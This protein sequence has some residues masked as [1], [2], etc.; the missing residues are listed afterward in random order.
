MISGRVCTLLP[1]GSLWKVLL[2]LRFRSESLVF[3]L[4]PLG[5]NEFLSPPVLLASQTP[6]FL[7]DCGGRLG[8]F[9]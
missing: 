5:L 2:V 4:G 1:P 7:R 9:S 3:V 6:R 8:G